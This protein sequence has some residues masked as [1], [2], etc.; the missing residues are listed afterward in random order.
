[1]RHIPAEI[2]LGPEDGLPRECA[3][4]LDTITTIAKTSLAGPVAALSPAK[5]GAVDA[6][7]HFALA[8]EE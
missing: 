7:I 1:M 2:P 5:I 6:A 4:N 3:V 8:L